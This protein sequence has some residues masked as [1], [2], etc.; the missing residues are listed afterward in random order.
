M[1]SRPV[2]NLFDFA[3]CTIFAREVLEASV[4]IIN[5]KTLIHRKETWREGMSKKDALRAVNVATIVAS[6]VAIAVI[7]CVALPLGI[8]SRSFDTRVSLIIEGVSK[9]VAAVCILQLSLKMP[10][11]LGVYVGRKK[12]VSDMDIGSGL[13][14]RSIR[15]NVAWNIWREVAECGVFLL[16]FFLTG[17]GLKAIPLSAIVGTVVGLLCGLGIH[18]ANRT[19]Q[20]KEWLAIFTSTLLLFLSTGLF[21]G[22]CGNIEKATKAYK[23]GVVNRR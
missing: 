1:A 22:G 20:R 17:Q 11:W 15:F 12:A 4:I 16:P 14:L 18:Y 7:T 8:L 3:V 2:A 13:T 6:L 21:S 19:L 5:Y 9:I 23:A 10:K